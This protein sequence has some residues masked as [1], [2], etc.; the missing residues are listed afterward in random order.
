[1]QAQ[2]AEAVRAQGWQMGRQGLGQVFF[3]DG[4]TI[5]GSCLVERCAWDLYTGDVERAIDQ[6]DYSIEVP[7]LFAPQLQPTGVMPSLPR[8]TGAAGAGSTP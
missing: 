4:Y 3:K 1:V 6:G 8:Q 5:W 2:F 7:E